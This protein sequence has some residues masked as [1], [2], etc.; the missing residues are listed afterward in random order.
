MKKIIIALTILASSVISANA[1]KISVEAYGGKG[2]QYVDMNGGASVVFE[3]GLTDDFSIGVGA[4]ASLNRSLYGELKVVDKASSGLERDFEYYH[5]EVIA[6]LFIRAKYMFSGIS[7]ASTGHLHPYF[8]VDGGYSINALSF[9]PG[10]SIEAEMPERARL[11]KTAKGLF[12]TP[13]IGLDSGKIYLSVG[14]NVQGFDYKN[15]MRTIIVNQHDKEQVFEDTFVRN[16]FSQ[17]LS[18]RIGYKF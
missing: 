16:N 10:E 9:S 15:S 8:A 5:N 12:Y 11:L 6:P 14:L 13:Q 7:F 3:Y 18:F 17:A 4:G 1:Q 2:L